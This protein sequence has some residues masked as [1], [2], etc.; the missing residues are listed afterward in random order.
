MTLDSISESEFSKSVSG[1]KLSHPSERL[2]GLSQYL[3]ANRL[4]DAFQVISNAAY[5]NLD[6]SVFEGVANCFSEGHAAQ[7]SDNL[8]RLKK[9]PNKADKFVRKGSLKFY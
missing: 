5:I 2:Y 3:L 1:E 7:L 4:I 9:N 8:T 6:N